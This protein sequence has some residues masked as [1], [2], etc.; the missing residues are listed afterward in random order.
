M[1]KLEFFS[2]SLSVTVTI[3]NYFMHLNCILNGIAIFMVSTD[4]REPYANKKS[5]D[6]RPGLFYK[7]MND[8][9]C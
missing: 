7:N 2:G 1:H 6:Q 8:I 4:H 5:P 3:C 9:S